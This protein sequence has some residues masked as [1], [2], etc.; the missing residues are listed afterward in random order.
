VSPAHLR[1]HVGVPQEHRGDVQG[2]LVPIG[3]GLGEQLDRVAEFPGKAHVEWVDAVDADLLNVPRLRG[4]AEGDLSQHRQLVGRVAAVHI[5]CRVGLGVP[6]LLGLSQCLIVRQAPL[7]HCGQ[8]EVRRAVEDALQG[9]DLVGRQ[10]LRESTH[11]WHAAG[12]GRLEADDPLGRP[13]GGEKLRAVGREQ[14]LVGRDDVLARRKCCQ[15]D[16]A[17]DGRAANEF[18]DDMDCRVGQRGSA[19]LTHDAGRE[20]DIPRLGRVPDDDILQRHAFPAAAGEAVGMGGED[21]GHPGADRAAT[22]E[23]DPEFIRHLSNPRSRKTAGDLPPNAVAGKPHRPVNS[24]Q[25][26]PRIS[27]SS[28]TGTVAA[29]TQKSL[30]TLNC[31]ARPEASRTLR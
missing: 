18:N 13:R 12:D 9:R 27:S 20:F 21:A 6:E 19:I 16:Y 28:S 25:P 2:D 11:D 31:A 29:L 5:K 24:T 3:P 7:G 1:K 22:D 23:R 4:H 15:D 8:D 14:R 10:T 26:G 30:L 17:G